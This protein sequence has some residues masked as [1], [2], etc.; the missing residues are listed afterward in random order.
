[1][2]TCPK[3]GRKFK[4]E[5]QSHYCGEITTVDEYIDSFDLEKRAYLKE[6]REIMQS[7]LPE[8][9]EKISWRMPTYYLHH[10]LIHFAAF[11]KHIGL[12][13]GAEGVLA[14]ASECEKRHFKYSKGAIQIPYGPLPK[15]FIQALA[16]WCLEN[17]Q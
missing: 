9:T 8:A 15:D 17:N 10:N 13:P 12:Y 1:M 7:C 3:C 11:N 5:N 16:L 2:W 4:K 6:V 14:F